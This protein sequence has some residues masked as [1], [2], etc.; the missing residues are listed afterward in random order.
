MLLGC[1]IFVSCNS[2]KAQGE[3]LG[4]EYCDCRKKYAKEQ[5]KTY[6]NFLSAFDSYGFKTRTEARQ[7]WKSLQDEATR[8]YSECKGKVDEKKKKVEAG[9]PIDLSL[10][11]P[12]KTHKYSSDEKY[13]SKNS[14][15]LEKA[16]AFNDALRYAANLCDAHDLN[17][18]TSEIQKK[19]LTVMPGQP[20]TALLKQNLVKRRITGQTNSYFERSW[21]WTISSANEIKS[22]SINRAE[23]VGDAYEI[24]AHLTLQ[25]DAAQYE[26]DLTIT[27]VLGQSDDWTIDYIQSHDIQIVKTGRYDDCVTVEIRQGWGSALQFTNNCDVSLIIGGQILGNNG[28]WTKFST[29][30]SGNNNSSVSYHGLEYKIDFIERL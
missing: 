25:R 16:N 22:F 4:K 2:P 24:D 21:A 23:K 1:V 9:F 8:K 30:I 27:C 14:R 12:N 15:N 3:K 26:A 20:D 19:I 17:I 13:L 29:R 5:E 6:L 28:E 18:D 7:K 10:F 11:D